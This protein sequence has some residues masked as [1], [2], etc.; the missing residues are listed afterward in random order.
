M[1]F[2]KSSLEAVNQSEQRFRLIT[3]ALPHMVWEIEPDGTISYINKQWADWTG[4]T[5][6]QINKGEW[7]RLLHPDDLEQLSRQW[8]EAFTNGKEFFGEFRIK[9]LNGEYYWFLFKTIS[10]KSNDGSIIKWVGTATNIDDEKKSQEALKESETSFRQL[11]DVMPQQVWT[12]DDKGQLDYV[13]LVTINY[14]GKTEQEIVG[15]GWQSVIHPDDI[16][17]VLKTWINSLQTLE[18]YQVEFRLKRKDET[19]RWHL[20][21]ASSFKN[22]QN[23][24]KWFGTNT[25]IEAHK[26]NEQRKDAFISMASHELK[27]P[28]TTIKGYAHILQI[29]FEKEGNSEAAELVKKMDGQINKLTKLIGDFLNV[30]KIEGQ[31]LQL[32]KADFDFKELIEE[33]VTGVQLTSPS[34]KI[35]IETDEPVSYHGDKL[36]L[37][38]VINNFLINAVKYSPGADKIIVRYEI[39]SNNIVVSIQDFGIGIEQ[40]NLT[41]IFNRFYRVDISRTRSDSKETSIS[42]GLG[43]PIARKVI[44]L[45]GGTISV[46]SKTAEG[47]EFIIRLPVI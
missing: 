9:N 10:I 7:G 27:T 47:A 5:L 6:E 44:E 1:E 25:D 19:Y 17:L 21:R 8:Q 30:S 2:N 29:K 23:Q 42:L 11:A 31:Q 18:D 39:I 38:Q 26:S 15:A 22:N 46:N 34:H 24:I 37:E 45:L 13:N 4:L 36:R 33:C 41:K 16:E 35:I 32:D 28:V 3:D 40:E 12:A 43:L 14:F 20:G